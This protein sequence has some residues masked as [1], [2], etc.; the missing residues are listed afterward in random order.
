[1]LKEQLR[2]VHNERSFLVVLQV[3]R[4]QYL[5]LWSGEWSLCSCQSH[6]RWRGS[7]DDVSEWVRETGEACCHRRAPA[8]QRKSQSANNTTCYQMCLSCVE[9]K[10][11]F[12]SKIFGWFK[13]RFICCTAETASQHGSMTLSAG[14]GLYIVLQEITVR[15]ECKFQQGGGNKFLEPKC[16]LGA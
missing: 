2:S 14:V 7:G 9:G 8:S 10:Y 4:P 11:S 1:M 5:W 6:Q 3:R 16:A 13:M 12:R 15:S